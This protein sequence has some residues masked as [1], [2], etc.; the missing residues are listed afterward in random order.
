[1]KLLSVSIFF[2]KD[3]N[4]SAAAAVCVGLVANTCEDAVVPHVLPFIQANVQQVDVSPFL[5][6][7]WQ[8]LIPLSLS[9]P[10]P[11]ACLAQS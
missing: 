1:M 4:L 10:I 3:W 7:N 6:Q 11:S 9:R 5:S 2:S 8:G